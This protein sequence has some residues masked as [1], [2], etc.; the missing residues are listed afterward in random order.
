[1]PALERQQV[2]RAWNDTAAEFPRESTIHELFE[3]QAAKR[4]DAT[5]VVFED[6]GL[7]YAE[8]NRR[9][10]RL[11]HRLRAQGV[12][13]EVRVGLCVEQS[14]WMVVALLGILKAGGAYV[15]LDPEYPPERL[16]FMLE[17]ARVKVLLTQG[18]LRERLAAQ[19]GPVVVEL[20]AQG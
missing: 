5:A 4:P 10:N 6:E 7:T 3:A 1:L 11:A 16:T 2:L 19:Q 9:A 18:G 15:P 17:D 8:L 20:D 13:P 14:T 12:G